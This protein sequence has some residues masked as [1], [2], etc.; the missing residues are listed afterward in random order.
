MQRRDFLGTNMLALAGGALAASGLN[1]ADAQPNEG[2]EVGMKIHAVTIAALWVLFSSACAAED[3]T[4]TKEVRLI[5]GDLG[6][7]K[8]KTVVI[9][10][11]AK[12]EKLLG[13]IKLTKKE[14][15]ACD[16]INH[17]VFVKDK[18]QITVSLCDHC[19]DVGKNTYV[20]PPEFYK[21]YTAYWQEAVAAPAEQTKLPFDT[22][23][24]YF[25]SNKFEP[26]V[27]ESFLVVTDQ[28]RFD[29]VFG[30]A[31]VM[32]DK[33]HRLP[34][35]AFKS[36]MVLAAVKRGNAFWE[37][38]MEGV[39]VEQGVVQLRYAVTSK[40]TPDTTFAC[41]LIVSV[42]KADYKAVVFIEDGK[43]VKRVKVDGQAKA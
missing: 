5:Q 23:S 39:T 18:G 33:S 21:L 36:N 2:Q 32:G 30:V 3:F 19:F 41:P 38:K 15:C 31:F 11:K 4:G 13:A 25:V 6:S 29:Q 20:M 28:A 1:A 14:P 7:P 17:A 10:D 35:D 43:N 27:A 24:G 40:A 42:P 34:K 22:Y 26:D 9:T 16:H 37:Y 8:A 12:I